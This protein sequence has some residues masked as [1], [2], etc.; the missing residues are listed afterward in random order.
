MHSSAGKAAEESC[1][2]GKK[3]RMIPPNPIA[4]ASNCRG[5]GAERVRQATIRIFIIDAVE[6]TTARSPEARC[7]L[8]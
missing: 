8:A 7:G 2:S 5:C 3:I 4:E 6:N 1:N